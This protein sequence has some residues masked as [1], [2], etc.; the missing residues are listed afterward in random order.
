[1]RKSLVIAAAA[2][3]LLGAC[4]QKAKTVEREDVIAAISKT[5][6][7]QTAAIGR[8][9]LN[10]AV[11][12]FAEDATL[13]T[14]GMPPAIGREAIKAVN[15]RVLKDPAL[16]I[17]IDEASRKF[18]ISAN[19]DLATT[20]YTSAWTH[21]DAISGKPVTERLVSQTTWERQADGT[22]QNVSDLN[23]IYPVVPAEVK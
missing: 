5:E 8:N 22:W 19:G 14:P 10:G 3:S 7:A 13:Y 15:E 23:A 2:L 16:N 4:T 1:M 18:W 6:E 11:A 12:V 20:T 9:D 17:V 21:T